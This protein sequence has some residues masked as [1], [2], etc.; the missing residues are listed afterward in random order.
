MLGAL[1]GPM[2]R[3]P[4]RTSCFS[5]ILSPIVAS[6]AWVLVA[7][8]PA[9]AQDTAISLEGSVDGGTEGREVRDAEARSL[10]SAPSE[11]V[12]RFRVAAGVW[13]GGVPVVGLPALEV[14]VELAPTSNV[15]LVIAASGA[16]SAIDFDGRAFDFGTFSG[17]VSLRM[18]ADLG[19]I[20]LGGGPSLRG[21]VVMWPRPRDVTRIVPQQD[22][23]G[24]VG[25]GGVAVLFAALDDLPLRFGLELEGGALWVYAP[26]VAADPSQRLGDGWI[27]ARV[28]CDVAALD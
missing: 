26:E 1:I 7:P 21:G 23:A 5:S 25:V 9:R 24:W 28:V 18:G 19:P 8:V 11:L 17:T 10:G 16:G 3:P 6:L 12:P 4:L 27:E 15:A 20:W 13:V 22:T 14:G 2:T